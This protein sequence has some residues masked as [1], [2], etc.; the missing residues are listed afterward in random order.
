MRGEDLAIVWDM[1]GVFNVYFTQVLADIGRV[2]GWPMDRLALGPTGEVFDEDYLDMTEGRL[3]EPEYLGRLVA[4]LRREGIDLDPRTGVDW[5]QHERPQTWDF[6]RSAHRA[7]RTQGILT[8]DASRWK[9]ERWWETWEQAHLFDAIVD[10]ATLG[11]RKPAPEVYRAA[12]EA[13]GRDPEACIFVDDM[14]VN[15]RGAEA[16]G[17]QSQLF[18]IMDP[19]GSL[20]ILGE[21]TGVR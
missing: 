1:G 8:N 16:I 11:F 7:G 21:R 18:D 5:S 17:M 4:G 20:R 19:A 3:D 14:P 15:C 9:G 10:V 6:I 2:E 13:L 12:C